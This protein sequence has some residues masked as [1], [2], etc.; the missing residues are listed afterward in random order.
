MGFTRRS[1]TKDDVRLFVGAGMRHWR[2]DELEECIANGAVRFQKIWTLIFGR[3]PRAG[4]HVTILEDGSEVLA[5]RGLAV[6]LSQRRHRRICLALG[7]LGLGLITGHRLDG[8][9]GAVSWILHSWQQLCL[10]SAVREVWL[11]EIVFF[12]ATPLLPL[13]RRLAEDALASACHGDGGVL[14]TVKEA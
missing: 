2:R 7:R 4:L 11:R 8:R 9:Q 3:L 6:T 13:S 12:G 1:A 14:S 10:S 5:Q